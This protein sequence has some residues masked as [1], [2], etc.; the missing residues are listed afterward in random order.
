[1][2]GNYNSKMATTIVG[3][4]RILRATIS[5][6]NNN[7]HSRIDEEGAEAQLETLENTTAIANNSVVITAEVAE[8]IIEVA[9]AARITKQIRP[10]SNLTIPRPMV[11]EAIAMEVVVDAVDAARDTREAIIIFTEQT[12]VTKT[13]EYKQPP[14]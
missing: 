7:N 1:M 12:N 13:K 2:A 8:R 10:S 3:M 4:M 9:V 11:L 14:V 6:N 5:L